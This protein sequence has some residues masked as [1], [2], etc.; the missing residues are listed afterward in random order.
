MAA[1]PPLALLLFVEIEEIGN[2]TVHGA[3]IGA[4]V[5]LVSAVLSALGAIVMF[6]QAALDRGPTESAAETVVSS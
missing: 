2:L 1:S 5:F 4:W 3:G 6:S